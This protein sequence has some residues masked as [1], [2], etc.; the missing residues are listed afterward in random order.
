MGR[1]CGSIPQVSVS[2]DVAVSSQITLS[3]SSGSS[4][5]AKGG[6]MNTH[7]SRSS[8]NAKAVSSTV[9]RHFATSFVAAASFAL[10][11]GHGGP[12]A[13]AGL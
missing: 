8:D 4:H 6:E 3:G 11:F 2:V 9:R 1:E 10:V 7:A 12:S 5:A 13:K